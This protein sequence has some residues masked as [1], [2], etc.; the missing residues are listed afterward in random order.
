MLIFHGRRKDLRV[1]DRDLVIEVIAIEQREALDEMH[2]L[3]VE[4]PRAIEP[5]VCV[6]IMTSMTRVSPSQRARVSPSAHSMGPSG[7][8]AVH[9]DV[10]KAV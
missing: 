5:R 6:E 10:T 8:L 4:V 7:M 1:L 9:A 3:A 2:L